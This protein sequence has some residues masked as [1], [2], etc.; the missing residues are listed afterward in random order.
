MDKRGNIHA[1]DDESRKERK[2]KLDELGGFP[3]ID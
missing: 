3:Q 1:L 2:R